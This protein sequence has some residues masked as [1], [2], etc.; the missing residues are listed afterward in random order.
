M[1]KLFFATALLAGTCFTFASSNVIK[2]VEAEELRNSEATLQAQKVL[3]PFIP[4]HTSCGE[5]AYVYYN[6]N[7]TIW[8]VLGDAWQLDAELCGN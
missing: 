7:S 5:T 4:V 2:N 3:K 6:S 8:D 1:K